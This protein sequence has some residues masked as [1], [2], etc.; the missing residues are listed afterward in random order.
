MVLLFILVVKTD[1]LFAHEKKD[2][3]WYF[4]LF[5]FYSIIVNTE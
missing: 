2:K 1:I 3:E 4:I 5:Y